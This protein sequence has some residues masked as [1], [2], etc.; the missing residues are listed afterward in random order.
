MLALADPDQVLG[1]SRF[2]RDPLRSFEAE[3]AKR[4]P[5]LSGTAEEVV[6][7]RPDLV[8]AGAF[9][10]RATRD[11]VRAQ[12]FAVAEFDAPRSIEDAKRQIVRAGELLGQPERARAAAA[13]IDA[14]L[15]RTRQAASSRQRTVL[16]LQRRGWVAGKDTLL[17]SILDAVGLRNAG[18]SLSGRLGRFASL[19]EIVRLRPDLLL[20]SAEERSAEDQGSALLEHPALAR[21]FPPERRLVL[22]ERYTAFCGGPALADAIERLAAELARP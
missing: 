15:S 1:L 6:R 19:E 18:A 17:T 7:L 20:V 13:R 2:A 16:P 8:L 12:G 22:P 11:L 5:V 10:R 14:S 3:A 21:L 4:F 9:T